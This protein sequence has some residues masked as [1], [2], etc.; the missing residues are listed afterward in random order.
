MAYWPSRY[1][2]NNNVSNTGAAGGG[3][4]DVDFT[5]TRTV[6]KFLQGFSHLLGH[7]PPE[8]EDEA[9]LA[10]VDEQGEQAGP[11]EDED[12]VGCAEWTRIADR[13]HAWPL[14]VP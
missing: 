12:Q 1:V 4:K 11:E 8:D 5:V 14:A 6:P 2:R 7:K 10:S 9:Q 3:R 13:L